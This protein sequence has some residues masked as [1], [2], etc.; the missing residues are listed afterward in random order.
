METKFLFMFIV[1]F[2]SVNQSVNNILRILEGEEKNRQMTA[3]VPLVLLRTT[4]R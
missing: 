2:M 4:V 1:L 3:A